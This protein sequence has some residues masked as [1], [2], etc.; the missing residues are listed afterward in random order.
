MMQLPP[1]DPT[2]EPIP[3]KEKNIF[4]VLV[5]SSDQLLVEEQPMDLDEIKD[6]CKKFLTNY[7]DKGGD[8]K[9]SDNPQKAITSIKTDRGTTY[10]VYIRVLD[11]VKRAYHEVRAEHMGITLQEYL[12][13]DKDDKDSPIFQR[14][15]KARKE[16]P[17][18]ISEAEPSKIGG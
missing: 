7:G 18:Q 15:E 9:S 3:Q 4:K 8:P 10:S 14:Y 2:Q 5:N 17:M 16:F 13:L 1:L 12:A 11:E 6:E